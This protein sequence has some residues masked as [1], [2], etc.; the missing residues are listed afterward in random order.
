[1][2]I[3]NIYLC[4]SNYSNQFDCF[5]VF[6]NDYI[7]I[8]DKS[9]TGLKNNIDSSIKIKKVPNVGYNIFSYL[10]FI[11]E[12]YSNI[13]EHI[14]FLKD[15][16]FQRHFTYDF[17][18]EKVND[19]NGSFQDFFQYERHEHLNFPISFIDN[20]G[21][22][23]EINNDWYVKKHKSEYLTSY[24]DFFLNVFNVKTAPD[25]LTFAPGANFIVSRERILKHSKNFMKI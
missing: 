3:D 12:N 17:F 5:D 14:V 18:L 23:C 15:N 25:T 9:Q 10:D 4:L 7:T 19:Y 8:Y 2:K 1:M 21:C 16:V 24:N 20:R 6:K 13:P 22:F 11:V